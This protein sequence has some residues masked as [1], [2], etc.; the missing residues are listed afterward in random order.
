MN[1]D[2]LGNK[3][4]EKIMITYYIFKEHIESVHMKSVRKT[5][6]KENYLNMYVLFE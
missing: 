3:T 5:M 1:R 6:F 2:F 4:I